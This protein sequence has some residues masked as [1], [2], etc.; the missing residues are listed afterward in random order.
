[1]STAVVIVNYRTYGE[2][3]RCFASLIPQL[4][5]DD[6]VVVVDYQTDR[7]ALARAIDGRPGVAS[8]P[9]P[10]NLGFAAGVNLAAARTRAPFLMLLNPDTIMEGPVIRGL[11]SYLS[12]HPDVGVAGARVLNL[13]GTVQPTARRFP[14]ATTL[15]G[16][17]STWLTNRFPDNW[18][19]RRNLIGLQNI[20]PGSQRGKPAHFGIFVVQIFE[21]GA[22]GFS[23]RS[24][25]QDIFIVRNFPEDL[26][27]REAAQ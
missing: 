18:F 7:E 10:D 26:Q 12:A 24:Q 5:S 19:S 14:D 23:G 25:R 2:L 16:G 17:R 9:R 13:D 4:A 11:E 20:I 3:S 8:I 21:D 27:G 6:E 22:R 1:M 15:L